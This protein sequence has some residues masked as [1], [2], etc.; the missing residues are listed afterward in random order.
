MHKAH[1]WYVVTHQARTVLHILAIFNQSEHFA[2][3]LT[4]PPSPGAR[5]AVAI[6]SAMDNS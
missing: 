6:T 1:P 4:R 2:R 5:R 3:L